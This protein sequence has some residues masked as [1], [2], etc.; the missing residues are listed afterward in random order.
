ML[1]NCDWS[2]NELNINSF[3][4]IKKILKKKNISYYA[5][6]DSTQLSLTY[7]CI[8]PLQ[9]IV[10]YI[11]WFFIFFFYLYERLQEHIAHTDICTWK[12][13]GRKEKYK[14]EIEREKREAKICTWN[15]FYFLI[16]YPCNREISKSCVPTQIYINTW[17]FIL[18]ISE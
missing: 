1:K 3:A 7:E 8:H 15:I 16:S 4:Y 2:V 17:I 13:Q 6:Q 5:S 11:L 9:F 18:P 12:L 10:I 14:V